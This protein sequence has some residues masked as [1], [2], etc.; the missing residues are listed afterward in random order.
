MKTTAKPLLTALLILLFVYAAVSKLINPDEFRAQLYRQPFAH[1]LADLLLYTLPASELLAAVLLGFDR[2]RLTGL[3]LSLGL[4]LSFTIYISLGLLH[5]WAKI[6]CS[7]GG[8]LSHMGWGAHLVFNSLFTGI[9]LTAI[10]LPNH[11][12]PPNT[13]P[14][15]G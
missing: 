10:L 15:P 12:H 14:S 7:C 1:G 2:T 3:F 5:Y 11:H 9:N 8:I 6:P 13:T 4:L